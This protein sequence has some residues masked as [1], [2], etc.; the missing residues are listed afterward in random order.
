MAGLGTL[1]PGLPAEFG[2]TNER[3]RSQDVSPRGGKRSGGAQPQGAEDPK[4][5]ERV[6]GLGQGREE[7]ARRRES[8]STQRRSQ[9]DARLVPFS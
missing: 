1:D 7:E 3:R 9:Q 6:H 4:A 5:H 2:G 8:R